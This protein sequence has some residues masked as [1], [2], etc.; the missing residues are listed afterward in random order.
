MNYSEKLQKIV[1]KNKSNV[2]IG[3]DTDLNKIPEYFLKYKDPVFEFNKKIIEITKK[4]VAGYKLNM[5]FYECLEEKGISALK[6]TLA[7]IPNDLLKICDAKRGDIDNTAEMYAV[8]YFDKYDFDAIT[9]N[10]YMGKDSIAPFL[11]R[12]DKVVFILALTSNSGHTDFQKLNIG[13]KYLYEEIIEKSLS[14][15]KD[16]NVGFVFGANHTEEINN[17]TSS[18]P[19]VPLLIPGIGAQSNDLKNLISNL[20]SNS[21]VINSSRG[22]IYS[23][24]KN[25]NSNEFEP[26]VRLSIMN[27]KND[28]NKYKKENSLHNQST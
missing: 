6:Q 3:L 24:E 17:F 21:F 28:I 27:L 18:N 16:N 1:S 11:K 20:H 19:D 5:A 26:A 22:I 15:S 14:W 8:T 23:A 12:K 9:L 13:S 10:A 7:A 2:V 25:Y 4:H